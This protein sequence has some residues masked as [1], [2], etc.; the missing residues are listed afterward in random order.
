MK[1]PDVSPYKTGSAFREE[2]SAALSMNNGRRPIV[3]HF[4]ANEDGQALVWMVFLVVIF[5]GLCALTVDVAHAMLVKRELQTSCDAA[6]LAAA[7]TLPATNYAAVAQSFSSAKGSLNEHGHFSVGTPTITPLCLTTVSNWG[8]PCTSTS[9][10]AVSVKQT[11]TVKTFFAGIL[12]MNAMTINA[13]STAAHGAKAKPYN[14]AIVLDTTPS[15]DYQ[16]NSCGKTQL[17]CATDGVQQLLMGLSPSL[18]RVSLFTFP[19]ITSTSASADTD[20]SSSQPTTGPYTFPSRTANSLSTMPYTT[21]S[22]KYSSTVQMTY[23]VTGYLT[24][25][26]SSDSA[27][28]LANNSALSNAVGVGSASGS[29]KHQRGCTGIQTSSQD[30]YYAGALYAAQAS[31]MTQQAANPGTENV[32][33]FLSDGNATAKVNNPGGAFQAGYNDMVSSSSQSTTFANASGNYPSWVGQCGQGV[34][35][36]NY[37]KS[38]ETIVYTVAYGSPSTSNSQNC[39]SDRNGGNHRNITPCQAMQQMSSGW[40]SGDTSHFYSDYNMTGGDTGCQASGALNGV[41]A[42]DDIFQS[43]QIGLTGSRLLPNETP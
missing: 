20:C 13:V 2:Y 9:P 28:S 5:L 29:G 14:V 33:I 40:S 32:I 10:N 42:L 7:Q 1:N 31:L 39:A 22:G 23:Q 8:I 35:A 11:A 21:G 30:T 36:A 12:G 37:A 17:Q 25:Y 4:V 24:N 34:D 15:M 6:A 19:N 41:T 27:T 26:R 38:L 3:R 16:D 18:D 43:I